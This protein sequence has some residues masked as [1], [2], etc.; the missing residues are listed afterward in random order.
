MKAQQC[1]VRDG[2]GEGGEGGG[3]RQRVRR[4]LWMWERNYKGV[5]TSQSERG[6]AKQKPRNAHSTLQVRSSSQCKECLTRRRILRVSL[7]TT[8]TKEPG[9]RMVMADTAPQLPRSLSSCGRTE[10]SIV[11]SGTVYLHT[12]VELTHTHRMQ[13]YPIAHN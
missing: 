10:N 7:L 1:A 3:E 13:C 6:R 8:G 12:T 4:T 2:V 5:E 11:C 9:S